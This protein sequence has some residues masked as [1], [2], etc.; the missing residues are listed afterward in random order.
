MQDESEDDGL[1]VENLLPDVAD[2]LITN[3]HGHLI[4]PEPPS[5]SES[6]AV[7]TRMSNASVEVVSA[8]PITNGRN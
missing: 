6:S 5:L 1:M 2:R 3:R 8:S 4:M 7:F